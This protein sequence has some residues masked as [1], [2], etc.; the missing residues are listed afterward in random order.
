NK[1]KQVSDLQREDGAIIKNET[2]TF[3]PQPIQSY[4]FCWDTVYNEQII[5]LIK[6][7][8]GLYHESTFLERDSEK[9]IPT[10]HST[11][12]QAAEIAKQAHVKNLILGHYSTR[13]SEIELFKKEAET[14]FQPVLLADDGKVFKF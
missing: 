6:E 4:A 7:V 1:L 8:D 3:D 13:Y 5:P 10:A 14:V 9:C 2:V 11:A 12:M